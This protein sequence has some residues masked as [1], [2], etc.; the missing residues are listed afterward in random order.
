MS[1]SSSYSSAV[2]SRAVSGLGRRPSTLQGG[3]RLASSPATFGPQTEN[4]RKGPEEACIYDQ[5]GGVGGLRCMLVA[6]EDT[7]DY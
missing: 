4:A 1:A 2:P 3:R 6:V 7:D 5:E